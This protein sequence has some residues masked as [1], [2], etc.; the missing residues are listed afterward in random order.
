MLN[1]RGFFGAAT[2][3]AGWTFSER[4]ELT[5]WGK[6][7][8]IID[9]FEHKTADKFHVYAVFKNGSR[10][11]TVV[12]KCEYP[13]EESV[14]WLIDMSKLMTGD[15]DKFVIATPDGQDLAEYVPKWG[16]V[17]TYNLQF[18]IGSHVII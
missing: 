1:R 12:N 11:H 9:M 7:R 10:F 5:R 13:T 18:G 2:A 15:F 3:L 4:S 14:S 16:I 17:Q 6:M 8:A